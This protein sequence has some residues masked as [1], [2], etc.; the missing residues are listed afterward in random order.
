MGVAFENGGSA[1]V[2]NDVDSSA[3]N[4]GIDGRRIGLVVA[5][6][7]KTITEAGPEGGNVGGAKDSSGIEVID[8]TGGIEMETGGRILL[9]CEKENGGISHIHPIK[10]GGESP[11]VWPTPVLR[12]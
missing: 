11:S 8:A 5:I 10:Y 2:R 1:M 7:P 6:A 9:T 4:D 12:E 3:D